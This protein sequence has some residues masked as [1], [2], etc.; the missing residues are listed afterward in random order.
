MAT[1]SRQ[2]VVEGPL[3]VVE[4]SWPRFVQWVLTGHAK[5]ACDELLCVDAIRSGR[6]RFEE[7]GARSTRVVFELVGDPESLPLD[8]IERL[9][10]HDLLAFKDYVE[11]R[12]GEGATTAHPGS[13]RQHPGE[14]PRRDSMLDPGE[15]AVF[16]RH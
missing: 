10:T 5:L 2:T 13:D 16:W 4:S 6:V 3:T 8:E 9:V 12:R 14:H 11:H 15:S 7:D 1:I